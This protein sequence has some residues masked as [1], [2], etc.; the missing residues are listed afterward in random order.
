VEHVDVKLN[1][2]ILLRTL[3]RAWI[4][5]NDFNQKKGSERLQNGKSNCW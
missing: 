5:N 3:Q 1:V 4:H 2:K